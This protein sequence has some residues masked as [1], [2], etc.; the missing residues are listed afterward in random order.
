MTLRRNPCSAGQVRPRHVKAA[1]ANAGEGIKHRLRCRVSR[2]IVVLS[3]APRLCFCWELGLLLPRPADKSPRQ[4][5]ERSLRAG[6][7]VPFCSLLGFWGGRLLQKRWCCVSLSGWQIGKQ[8]RFR[9]T[10]CPAEARQCPTGLAG[11]L[12]SSRSTARPGPLSR[13]AMT[14][15][16]RAMGRRVAAQVSGCGAG[17]G[18]RLNDGR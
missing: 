3:H 18:V 14:A 16:A 15:A 13:R 12:S 10:Q 1:G 2:P 7:R 9:E 11:S 6:R 8:G 17:G 5:A 4:R